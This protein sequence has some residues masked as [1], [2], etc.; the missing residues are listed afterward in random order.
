MDDD[1]QNG[2]KL[3]ILNVFCGYWLPTFV[4]ATAS[5][6]NSFLEKSLLQGSSAVQSRDYIQL[7]THPIYAVNNRTV[8]DCIQHNTDMR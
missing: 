4:I 5:P 2:I 1:V 8:S 7:V 3:Y 6:R